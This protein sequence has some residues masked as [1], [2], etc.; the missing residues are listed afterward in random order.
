MRALIISADQFEDSELLAPLQMLEEADIEVDIAPQDY[1]ANRDPQM[2]K[3][4]E[5][6]MEQME[7]NPPKVPDFSER[8]KL[9]LPTLPK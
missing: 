6:I 3:S 9:P 2:D 4:I 8:P 1:V 5:V 7:A